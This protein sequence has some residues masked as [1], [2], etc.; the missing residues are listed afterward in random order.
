MPPTYG[1]QA[2]LVSNIVKLMLR[3]NL[4]PVLK[5]TDMH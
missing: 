5:Y 1:V 3:L 2:L 4:F